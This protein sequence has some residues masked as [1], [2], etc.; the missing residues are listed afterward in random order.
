MKN[1]L[2]KGF[3]LTELIVVIVIIGILAAVLIPTIAGYI[4]KAKLSND[5]T[6]AR[7]MNYILQLEATIDGVEEFDIF[8]VRQ[9]LANNDFSFNCRSKDNCFW[10]DKATNKIVIEKLDDILTEK[11]SADSRSASREIE[12]ISSYHPNLLYLSTSDKIG[13]TISYIRNFAT[14]ENKTVEAFNAKLE[15]SLKNLEGVLDHLKQFN[16]S[17]T[18]YVSNNNYYINTNEH[19]IVDNI[20]FATNIISIPSLPGFIPKSSEYILTLPQTVSYVEQGAF[21]NVNCNL[22]IV[23]DYS[24]TTFEEGSISERLKQCNPLI[25]EGAKISFSD[26]FDLDYENC[27]IL[28]YYSENSET[29]SGIYIT[30]K[31]IRDDGV[32][33]QA[34]PEN[35]IK[36]SLLPNAKLKNEYGNIYR[37]DLNRKTVGNLMV[38][39]CRLYDKNGNIYAI[40]NENICILNVEITNSNGVIKYKLPFEDGKMLDYK[41]DKL[42]IAIYK[43]TEVI[44]EDDQKVGSL[45]ISEYNSGNIYMLKLIYNDVVIFEKQI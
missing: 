14:E 5:R 34:I 12:A 38:Y 35:V 11:V 31:D 4:E 1:K 39:N 25:K 32:G 40:F 23:C 15:S 29:K 3:T 41:Y 37:M 20:V 13:E 17:N 19:N 26:C 24:K 36:A 42:T 27:D 44:V 9:I 22:T 7:N 6:D 2:K 30:D 8:K 16:P 43:G 18:L 45:T 33:L 10:Y 21:S 28:Y